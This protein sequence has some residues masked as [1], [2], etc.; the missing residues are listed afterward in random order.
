MREDSL[1]PTALSYERLQGLQRLATT[2]VNGLFDTASL[3]SYRQSVVGVANRPPVFAWEF[4]GV[5][6]PDG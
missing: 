6:R 4:S 5:V 2:L 3:R 1:P